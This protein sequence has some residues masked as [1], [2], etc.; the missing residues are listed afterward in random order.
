ME[1]CKCLVVVT[2]P[3][4]IRT[5]RI[6]ARDDIGIDIANKR[7]NSQM[8]DSQYKHYADFVIENIGDDTALK[9]CVEGIYSKIKDISKTA[10]T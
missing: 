1:I 7:I 4:D 6:M 8:S 3:S 5:K 2:A 9:G 10:R